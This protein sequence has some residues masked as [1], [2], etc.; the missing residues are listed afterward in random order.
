[1]NIDN[2]KKQLQEAD[3]LTR[4]LGMEFFSTPE[5]DTLM[6]KMP[7]D[8]RNKQV[9]GFLSGGATISLAEDLAGIGSMA[10]CPGKMALG[11]NVSASH[12]KAILFGDTLTAYG[13]L[14][15]KGNT[16]HQW[17]VELKNNAGE[18][19]SVVEVTNFIT[20]DIRKQNTGNE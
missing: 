1:M 10:L 14:L 15:H 20:E 4:T 13:R 16:L 6:A 7:V 9:F 19:I 11:I 5:P 18:L 17:H 2:V 12:V 3:G 8:D